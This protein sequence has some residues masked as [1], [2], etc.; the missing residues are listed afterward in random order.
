MEATL[1]QFLTTGVFALLLTFVRFGTVAMIMPGIGDSYVPQNVRL[2]LALSLSFVLLPITTQ[3]LPAEPPGTFYLITLIGMEFIIGLFFGTIARIF[4]M[5]LDTAGMIISTASGLANAQVFN[6]SLASQGSLVGA[7][8]TVTGVVVFFALDLHHV[9][10]LGIL[11]SYKVFPVGY[12]PEAGS[13]AEFIAKTVS[14]SFAVG[15]KIGA[16]FIVLTLIIYIGMGVLSRIM[17]QVQVFLLALPLQIL[18]SIVLLALTIIASYEYW[19]AEF[20]KVIGLLLS[21][22]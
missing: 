21:G 20:F 18:L 9:L 11:E 19:S 2:L 12:L 16:P 22:S 14:A 13:M 1:Q 4:M 7:F 3:Y 17:P 8:L 15:V 5:A 10:I 6:P